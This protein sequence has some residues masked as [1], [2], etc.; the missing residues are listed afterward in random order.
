MTAPSRLLPADA[1][2]VGAVG[3]RTRPLRAALSALGIAIG[4]AAMVCVVGVASSSRESL[5][6]QL[7]ALGTNLLRVAPGQTIFGGQSHLPAAAV[8]MIGRIPPVTSVTA[9][10]RAAEH[11]R[12]PQ[13]PHPR[14]PDRQPG[15]ARSA[16]RLARH[17]GRTPGERLLAQPGHRPVPGG[18]ARRG[19]RQTPRRAPRQPRRAGLARRPVVHRGR[20]APPRPARPR[21]GLRRLVG[22]RAATTS[23]RFDRHPTT[24]YTRTRDD[25]VTAV[26]AILAATA[27]PQNPNEVNVSRPSDA[28]AAKH[29]TDATLTALLLGLGAV[30]LLVGGVGVA[31][32]MVIS[33]LE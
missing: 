28:L 6:R 20:R 33:V 8:A 14:R 1:A 2:R 21:T 22:W 18:G 5:N 17:R 10:R 26:A 30:A 4:I 29:A 11:P 32:T 31:N 7:A 25:A 13:R 23:L 3:L 15:G 19:G 24:I 9:H 16:D 12:V 27:N